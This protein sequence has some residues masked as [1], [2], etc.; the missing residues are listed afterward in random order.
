MASLA[1][2]PLKSYWDRVGESLPPFTQARSTRLYFECERMLLA[3]HFPG[4]EKKRLLKTDLWDEAKNSQILFWAAKQGAE[5]FGIDIS[6]A[7]ALEAKGFFSRQSSAKARAGFV[8]SDLRSLAFPDETFD[9]LY[10]M[11]TI[12]HFPEYS[13]AV[14]ECFRVLKKGGRA[15]IGVPNKFDPFLRPLL[16][17]VLNKLNLYLY[18]YEKSFSWKALRMLLDATGFRVIARGGILFLPGWLRMLDLFLY[19]K[20]PGLSFL[21]NPLV[22][23]FVFLYKKIPALSRHGYLIACVVQKP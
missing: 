7:I 18:G 1:S 4:L 2:S 15:I 19:V 11:G 23:P 20:C 16:V 6:P 10:S 17:T 9:Y 14:Q 3:K 13:L 22:W 12:E 21:M 5:I 8:V